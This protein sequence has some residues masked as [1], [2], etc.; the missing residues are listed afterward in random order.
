VALRF[1]LTE[2]HELGA[3]LSMSRHAGAGDAEMQALAERSPDHNAHREDEPYRRA[4]IGIYAR[5]AATLHAL[6]GTEA[7]RHAVAPQDPYPAPTNC[8]PT[9]GDRASLRSHHAAGADRPAAGAADARGAGVRLPPG[10]A[11]P[12]PELRPARGRGGRA[13]ARGAHRARLRGAGRDAPPQLLLRLLAT[14]RGRC[15]CAARSTALAR[16]ELEI[17][18]TAAMRSRYGRARRSATT[19]SATP[20]PVSDLLEVLLLQRSAACCAARWT[21]MP[22]KR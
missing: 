17:F 21:T 20:S 12:A 8:W 22:R 7:L 13:A 9:C 3:E 19:S 5:L 15:A 2:L 6:T 14:T 18:E 1:Y 4:L 16:G 11:G 10:H